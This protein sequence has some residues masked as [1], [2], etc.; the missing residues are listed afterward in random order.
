[1]TL[2][3]FDLRHP[4]ASGRKPAAGRIAWVPTER[5]VDGSIVVL[6]TRVSVTLDPLSSAQIEPGIYLFHEEVVGGISAYRVV[7][8]SLEA[9][10]SSLVAIDP[11]TLDPAS[12]P[13]A[14]WYAFVETLN[15]AN[16]DMLASA[17]AS[18]HSAELAQL[19]ATGSQTAASASALAASNSAGAAASSATQ[20]GTA[21]D[22]AVSAQGSAAGYASAAS[23]SAVAASDSASSAAASASSASTSAGTA[24]TKAAEATAAVLGF[25]VGTVSTVAPSEAASATITGPAGSRVLNLSIPRGAVPIFSVAETTT[26]PETPGAT[27]L[28]GQ[29]GDKGDPGGFVLGTALG[30]TDLNTITAPGVY[31]QSGAP[32]AGLNYPVL[33]LG[34]LLVHQSSTT[35]WLFQEYTPTATTAG[36]RARVFYR[37]VLVSGVW[38]AWQAYAST[39][40]DQTAGRV[41]YQWDDLN[42]REQIIY[43]D[44]GWRDISSSLANGFLGSLLIRRQG[45]L[46]SV[47]GAVRCATGL[48]TMNGIFLAALPTGFL[49]TGSPWTFYTVRCNGSSTFFTLYKRGAELSFEYSPVVQDVYECRF[50]ISFSTTDAWP[51][52]LPGTASGVIPNL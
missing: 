8:N 35:P 45:G 31:R 6:P 16:A 40:V 23:G 52:A 10:Y 19:S 25:S 50:E 9:D 42:Q 28:Q 49:A 17:L 5:K 51:T 22:G 21:R 46:V 7:P 12:Q 4:G 2:V 26:G 36:P 37:R 15:A 47:R 38:S 1:M 27:G 13:E 32:S 14:A 48:T 41:I 29:K 30:T 34:V 18:Q 39:R 24:I 20:A 11:A 33:D 3:H 44:T 43:S